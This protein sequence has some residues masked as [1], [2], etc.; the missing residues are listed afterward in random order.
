MSSPVAPRTWGL[1]LLALV[2]TLAAVGLGVWQYGA[3]QAHREVARTDL[4][5]LEP[6]SLESVIGPDDPFPGGQLGHPVSLTGSWLPTSTVYI[7]GRQQAGVEGYWVVTSLSLST[8]SAVPVVRGWAPNPTD[9]PPPPTGTARI[10][11]LLQAPEGTGEVDPDRSDDVLPQ[12][13]V[14]DLIQHLD[15]DIYGAYVVDSRGDRPGPVDVNDG[16]SGLAAASLAQLP[17]TG[18]FTSLRNILYA[19]EWWFFGAFAVYIWWRWVQEV[20]AE[21]EEEGEGESD[22][23]DESGQPASPAT[24]AGTLQR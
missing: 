12:M 17:Q 21:G 19:F 10:V 22:E 1:H 15:Q 20:R 9:A 4:T 11:G 13:R 3:W 14:A 18:A 23:G 16:S 7:S 24:T 5:R 8:G 6:V 2:L